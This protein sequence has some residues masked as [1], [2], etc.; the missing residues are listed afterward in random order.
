MAH[1]FGIDIG[2]SNVKIGLVDSEHGLIEKVKY[3]TK[4]VKEKGHFVNSF[5]E[6]LQSEFDKYPEVEENKKY[7]KVA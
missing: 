2:G 6:I 5:G 3:P 4:L 1:F 7:A